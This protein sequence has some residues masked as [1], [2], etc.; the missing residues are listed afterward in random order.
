MKIKILFAAGF[1][2]L[3]GSAATCSP[4]SA[5]LIDVIYKGFVANG[6]PD[7]I[8]LFGPPGADLTGDAFT[9]TFAMDTSK[10]NSLFTPTET[11]IEGG[12]VY[13]IDSPMIWASLQINGKTETISGEG[14]GAVQ[15]LLGASWA[16]NQQSH[17]AADGTNSMLLYVTDANGASVGNIPFTI[18][19]P[20]VFPFDSS[21]VGGG[22]AYFHN[23]DLATSLDLGPTE[24]IYQYPSVG[25][26]EAA[27][28]AMLMVG[29][30][31]L[32]ALGYRKARIIRSA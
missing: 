24:L 25:V 28:W 17:F 12:T 2:A 9:A 15:T 11:L 19:V 29:F 20:L 13:S 26:P 30:S 7:Y 14:N 21:D 1:I 4:A 32:G 31:G 23:G 22:S 18:D 3:G 6:T 10:G 27:T 8:G 16:A 5:T